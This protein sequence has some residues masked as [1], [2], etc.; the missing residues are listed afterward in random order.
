[1]IGLVLISGCTERTPA[2]PAFGDVTTNQKADLTSSL[3]TSSSEMNEN[4]FTQFVPSDWEI[5]D[6]QEG[7]MNNDGK[8]DAI[9]IIQKMI[10]NDDANTQLDQFRKLIILF[11][12]EINQYQVSSSSSM[13]IMCRNCGGMLGDPYVSTSILDNSF[14]IEHYGGSRDRWNYIHVFNWENGDWFLVEKTITIAD[15]LLL[16]SRDEYFNYSTGEHNTTYSV[17]DDYQNDPEITDDAKQEIFTNWDKMEKREKT[18]I[19][20]LIRLNDFD[21]ASELY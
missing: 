10:I 13:A 2:I 14:A 5:L 3:V 15:N 11:Q 8:K 6:K 1:M 16:T 7:D 20:S 17:P 12:N 4:I 19:K 9:L 21:I 18:K